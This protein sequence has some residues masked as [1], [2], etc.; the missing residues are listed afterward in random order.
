MG[1]VDQSLYAKK[2]LW[3]SARQWHMTCVTRVAWTKHICDT[4]CTIPPTPIVLC[5]RVHSCQLFWVFLCSIKELLLQAVSQVEWLEG[6]ATLI[7]NWVLELWNKPIVD[8]C[9]SSGGITY[10]DGYLSA[11]SFFLVFTVWFV[12][13]V[14]LL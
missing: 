6:A 7:D 12:K 8:I 4:C 11:L 1:T 14:I 2:T 5:S 13:K 10:F 9:G 3:L